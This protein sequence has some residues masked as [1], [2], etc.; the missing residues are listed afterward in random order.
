VLDSK[1]TTSECTVMDT[2]VSFKT[3]ATPLDMRTFLRS[4]MEGTHVYRTEAAGD[5]KSLLA[6]FRSVAE[7]LA[8]KRR[9]NERASMNDES[10]YG[11]LVMCDFSSIL[12]VRI[13]H[14]LLGDH[15]RS[16]NSLLCQIDGRLGAKVWYG[17]SAQD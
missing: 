12:I 4:G 7:D 16:R 1:D 10:P 15:T 11:S 14:R 3:N 17:P 8:A 2:L 13:A 5:K 9:R 6:T